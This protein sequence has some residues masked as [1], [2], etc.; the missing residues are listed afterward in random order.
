[1]SIEI[2]RRQALTGVAVV[3]VGAPL[4]AACSSD[5]GGSD[6][7]T[8]TTKAASSSPAPAE[9]SSAGGGGAGALVQSAD[10]PEGGGVILA[11]AQVVVTQPKAGQFKCFSAICTH[12]G[13]P[14][15]DVTDTINCTC[16]GSQFSITDGS[17]VTPPAT[18][19]LPD[20]AIKVEGGAIVQV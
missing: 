12:A 5:S 9:S 20:V 2:N 13:C 6:T 18:Q 7:S 3:G 17:V 19:P 15:S 10:V 4:L 16:H 11:D 8:P 14:V 1:M